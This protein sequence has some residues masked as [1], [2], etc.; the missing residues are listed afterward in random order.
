[1]RARRVGLAAA[2]I[3]WAMVVG[4]AGLA[5][6]ASGGDA[7][8]AEGTSLEEE[9]DAEEEEEEGRTD[10]ARSGPY[11]GVSGAFGYPLFEEQISGA[12]GG[13]DFEPSWG[14][15]A[16][17]GLRVL[18]FL[19]VE[20][21]YEWMTGFE[22]TGLPVASDVEID[23]HTLTGNLRF[24]VPAWQVHPYVLTGIGVT[25]YKIDLG[26]LGSA[27][28]DRFAARLGGGLDMDVTE[29]LVVNFEATALLTVNDLDFDQ[30]SISSLHYLSA[31]VGLAYRF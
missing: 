18:P 9:T 24:F 11:V 8:G 26:A 27:N 1:M 21:Q 4:G 14:L 2:V 7:T 30:G 12:T 29:K 16:R 17:L 19:A 22:V 3:G 28:Q 20:A 6:A 5:D 23:G 25:R 13:A 10:Y 31:N 15:D